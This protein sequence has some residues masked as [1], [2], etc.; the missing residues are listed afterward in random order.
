MVK[1]RSGRSYPLNVGLL[2]FAVLLIVAGAAF[3][4]I[5][6]VF[7]GA[8]LL[9]VAIL[10]G[11]R[12]ISLPQKP[13]PPPYTSPPARIATSAVQTGKMVATQHIPVSIP[14]PRMTQ[15]QT[16]AGGSLFPSPIL[17]TLNP[18]PVVRSEVPSEKKEESRDEF[19]TLVAILG[20][21]TLFSRRR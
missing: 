11:R 20:L 1:S 7:L 12:S 13:P 17:P 9:V 10:P 8:I 14:E 6:V 3:G 21:V 15:S 18:L 2:F 19:L 4:F 16:P 5:V